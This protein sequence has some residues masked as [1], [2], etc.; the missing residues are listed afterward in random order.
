MKLPPVV[1]RRYEWPEAV[2]GSIGSGDE[3][4]QLCRR[5][6]P[7]DVAL[8]LKRSF[9]ECTSKNI[10]AILLIATNLSLVYCCVRQ[11]SMLS[12]GNYCPRS[13]T[14]LLMASTSSSPSD[15]SAAC[16]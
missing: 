13:N 11:N 2:H 6:V 9:P 15:Q 3:F 10:Y 1:L 12:I 7:Y 8:A 5:F 16:R 14:L 4:S